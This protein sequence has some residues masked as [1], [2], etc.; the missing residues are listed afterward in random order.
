M[1]AKLIAKMS[2]MLMAKISA[3]LFPLFLAIR[4]D[5]R[6]ANVSTIKTA[7]LLAKMFTS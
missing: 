2:A 3:M 7:M 5:M 1:S 6:M 4:S